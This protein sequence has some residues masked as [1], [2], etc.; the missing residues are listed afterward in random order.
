[1]V[2]QGITHKENLMG[3]VVAE[4]IAEFGRAKDRIATALTTTPDDKLGWSPSPTA[5]TPVQ[6]AAHAALS[7]AGMSDMLHGKPFPFGDLAEVDKAFRQAEK[8]YTTREQ[9]L[10]L[11]EKNSAEYVAWMEGL[12]SAQ[13]EATIDLPFG[14]IP[15]SVAITFV[16]DHLRGHAAQIEYLQ[17]VLGDYDW[18]M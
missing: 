17:T 2:R 1:M 15:M 16:A 12:T 10:A 6:I 7:I 8:A 14:P 11:L 4:A 5:R 13:I 9:A 3:D 18:H